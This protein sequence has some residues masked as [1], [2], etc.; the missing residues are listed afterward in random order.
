MLPYDSKTTLKQGYP[1][2][3]ESILDR[4]QEIAEGVVAADAESVDRDARWPEAG[5]R[6][7]QQAGLGGLTVPEDLGGLGQGSFR[8]AQVCEILG[9]D[10]Y[11]LSNR[12][13]FS[14]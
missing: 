12:L 6:A 5:I 13:S 7:L 3:S 9:Q 8:V 2:D 4:V 11:M 14:R 10:I 1:Q